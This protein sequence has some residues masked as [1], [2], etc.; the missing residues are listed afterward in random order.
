V[1]IIFR[2]ARIVNDS[3]GKYRSGIYTLKNFGHVFGHTHLPKVWPRF[4]PDE[5]EKFSEI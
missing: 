2:P 3:R 5:E 1:A 4:G